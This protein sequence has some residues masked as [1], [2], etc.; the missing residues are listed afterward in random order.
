MVLK[1]K[2]TGSSTNPLRFSEIED[3]F[4]I[5][6]G[7]T[8]NPGKRSLGNYRVSQSFGKIN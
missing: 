2:T 5:N 8:I 1:S 6:S 3:E 7:S 4:G